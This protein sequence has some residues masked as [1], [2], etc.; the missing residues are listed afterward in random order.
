MRLIFVALLLVGVAGG[1]CAQDQGFAQWRAQFR[2]TALA[3]GI[4]SAT[5]DSAMAGV[6][7]IPRIIELDHAQP[8][9]KLVFSEYVRRLDSAQRRAGVRQHMAEDRDLLVRVGRRFHVQPRFIVAL[10]GIETDFGK[11][12]GTYPVIAALA[13]LAYD[14]R[15][16]ELF[17]RE[18]I[19]A[20]RIVQRDRIPPSQLRGSWAGAV[21]TSGPI[22]LT[23]SPRSRIIWQSLVGATAKPGAGT[24]VRRRTCHRTWSGS[25]RRSRCTTGSVS[26]SG[27]PMAAISLRRRFGR[28]C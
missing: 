23:S 7:P 2:D 5:F 27:A 28:R 13:T 14:G 6:Q 15:R 16:S 19:A 4:S 1:A 21:P 18:L 11:F 10:W 25:V 17:S 20:L 3:A 8:E 9:T 22:V 26:V 12:P 24:C